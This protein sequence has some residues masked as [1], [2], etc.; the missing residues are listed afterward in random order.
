[1]VAIYPFRALRPCPQRAAEIACPPY[2]VMDRHEARMLAQG[3]PHSFLHV[4]RADADFPD[5]VPETSPQVYQ[6]GRETLD[7]FQEEGLLIQ[8][9]EPLLYI[10]RLVMDGRTQ[11][12]LVFT[13]S[14]DDYL[15]GKI[16]RHELTL[17]AKE[18]DRI[19]HFDVCNANT[20]PI[21]LTYY[22]VPQIRALM[23][24]WIQS[25]EPVAD[26]VSIEGVRHSSWKVDD[27]AVI[28]DLEALFEKVPALY[29]ADGH[30]RCAS[31]KETC[32]KRRK[33]FPEAPKDAE[34]NRFLAVAFPDRDLTIMAYNRVVRDQNGLSSEEFLKRV[35]KNFTLRR[36][37]EEES[38][39]TPKQKGHFGLYIDGQWWEMK[40]LEEIV[41]EDPVESLDVSLLQNLILGPILAI[42]DPRKSER[43]DFIGG[44]RG[45]KE[46]EKR[47]REGMALAFSM[48]PTSMAEL[49][50]VADAGKIMPPKSTW[51]EPKLYSGLFVHRLS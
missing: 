47:C 32:L 12:G 38:P 4:T 39:F 23:T 9:A 35:S 13:A 15:I 8:D 5:H 11:T 42:E 49:L 6:K 19:R 50:T 29:I 18:L 46:L 37:N 28:S 2:D 21:Y 7:R 48:F 30:H 36:V 51:F 24:S 3:R 31:A 44:I 17:K 22:E 1:M 45:I 10:Y 25:H 43:I 40:V 14:V 41:P 20:A 34:F 33:E 26:F 16:K 27:P